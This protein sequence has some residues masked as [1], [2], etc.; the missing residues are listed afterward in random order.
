MRACACVRA[1]MCVCMC[2]RA[3]VPRICVSEL[4]GGGEGEAGVNNSILVQ[5][6][7]F[8][9]AT[10]KNPIKQNKFQKF[11]LKPTFCSFSEADVPGRQREFADSHRGRMNE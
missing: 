6:R 9:G 10:Q 2:L 5:K 8:T 11:N 4:G 1:C 3:C 7:I